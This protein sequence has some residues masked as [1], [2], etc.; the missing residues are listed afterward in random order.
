VILTNTATGVILNAS[1]DTSGSYSFPSIL[2]G[3]Y[4]LEISKSAFAT[5]KLSQFK[6]TVGQRVEE[7]GV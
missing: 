5:Y 6:V 4:S 1:R 7:N 3:I 2:P